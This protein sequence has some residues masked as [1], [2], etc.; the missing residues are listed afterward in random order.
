[1]SRIKGCPVF[2]AVPT[3]PKI[4]PMATVLGT[5][6]HVLKTLRKLYQMKKVQCITQPSK[7][8]LAKGVP[9]PELG[10]GT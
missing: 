2:S 10:A 6:S 9:I 7:R 1:M 4:Q 8:A 3:I 5:L